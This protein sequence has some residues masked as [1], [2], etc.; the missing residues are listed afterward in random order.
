[1]QLQQ[2]YYIDVKNTSCEYYRVKVHKESSLQQIIRSLPSRTGARKLVNHDSTLKEI[3]PKENLKV[4][5][6]VKSP[7]ADWFQIFVK[8]PGNGTITLQVFSYT[9]IDSLKKGIEEKLNLN[10]TMQRLYFGGKKLE[11]GR[12]TLSDY[13]ISKESTV[14][15]EPSP[16]I[17]SQ[18]TSRG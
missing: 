12:R 9:T 6:E 8:T 16:T 7:R 17:D 4:N 15:L 5:L 3:N 2:A 13:Y 14:F 10:V 1:M 18:E 11:D